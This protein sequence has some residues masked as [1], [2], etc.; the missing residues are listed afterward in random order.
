MTFFLILCNETRCATFQLMQ[1]Y[2]TAIYLT[3]NEDNHAFKRIWFCP[4]LLENIVSFLD[5]GIMVSDA[6]SVVLAVSLQSQLSARSGLPT[7]CYRVTVY[8]LIQPRIDHD[9]INKKSIKSGNLKLRI[10]INTYTLNQ[11]NW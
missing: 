10:E 9:P 1:L 3:C 5:D 4:P 2:K 11:W 7:Y 8:I 6:R